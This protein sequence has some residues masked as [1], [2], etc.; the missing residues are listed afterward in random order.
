MVRHLISIFVFDLHHQFEGLDQ[1]RE[2]LDPGTSA[3]RLKL[4]D[5]RNHIPNGHVI[6]RSGHHD[7]RDG[8]VTDTALWQ[9]NDALECLLVVLVHCKT[10]ITEHVFDLLA[11]VE[12]NTPDDAVFDVQSTQGLLKRTGLG[13]RTV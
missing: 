1:I 13:V 2:S 6:L 3:S 10:Q 4:R 5:I 7:F 11:L 8:R 9:I 12:R